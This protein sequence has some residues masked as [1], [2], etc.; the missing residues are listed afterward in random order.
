M[1]QIP[2]S[3]AEARP[4]AARRPYVTPALTT[5]GRV[6][7]LTATNTMSGSIMD[8]GPNNSKT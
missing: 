6:S 4:E 7:D 8:G 1:T 3:A 5:F 2:D